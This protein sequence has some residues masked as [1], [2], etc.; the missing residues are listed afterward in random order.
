VAEVLHTKI[1][2]V[3]CGNDYTMALSDDHQIYVWG[4]GRTGVLGVGPNTKTLHQAQMI[5]S[6]AADSA[7]SMSAGWAH[8]ACLVEPN[9]ERSKEEE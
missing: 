8:A 7:V 9:E 4:K 1:I 3:V 6:L 5:N 2:D